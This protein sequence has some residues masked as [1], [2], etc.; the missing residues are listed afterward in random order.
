[1]KLTVKGRLIVVVGIFSVALAAIGAAGLTG[2]TTTVKGLDALYRE[3]LEP[4]RTLARITALIADNRTQIM[5]AIQHNP[6]NP[7]SKLHDHP[8][9]NHFDTLEKNRT[10]LT[11]LYKRYEEQKLAPEEAAL[12]KRFL[13]LRTEYRNEGTNPA[14]EALKAG[15][16]QQA[17]VILL[18]KINPLFKKTNDVADELMAKSMAV[19]RAEYQAADAAYEQARNLMI[20]GT[21]LAIVLGALVCAQVARTLVRQLGGEPD[22]AAAIASQIAVGDLSAQVTVKPGDTASLMAAMQRMSATIQALVA[23]TNRMSAEHDKGEIDVRIDEARFQGAFQAMAKGVNGMVGN[24]LDIIVKGIACFSEF[25]QGNLAADIEK[26]PGKKAVLNQAID[27]IRA[28]IQALVNDANTLA[29]AAVEGR[30]AVRADPARHQGEFRNIIAGLNAV[31]EAIVGP[32]N[33]INRVMAAVESG[34]LTQSISAEYRG[35][36]KALCN[37]VN[38]TV[39]K[40]AQTIGEVNA[41]AEA[42]GAA[43]GQVSATAQS[44]S[45]SSSEQAASVEQTTASVEQ[46]AGS[47]RQNAENARVADAMSAEGSRKAAEGGQAVTETVDAMRQIAQKIGIVDDIAYQTNLLALN[48]AIEAARA[49]E[50]GKGFA[51]VAA[52]V[53]KLAERSQVA[54]QEIGQLAV[55]SVGTAERAGKLLDEIVPATQKTADLVQEIT[56]TSEEQT[57]AVAQVNTAMGQ[58]NK[59]TQQNA[60]ASEELAATA[61]EMSSQ[62]ESLQHA[63]AFFKLSEH[64]RHLHSQER[65]A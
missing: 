13:E 1:M 21:L 43:T 5:L 62:A 32:V 63:M 36:M 39:D 2:M 52:E 7:L 15:Q 6:D 24:H 61:E 51:V 38:N 26:Q 41:T 10:E 58:M 3:R 23:E 9:S 22:D 29:Q 16:F 54:A 33:E 55:S 31:M 42:L 27:Q 19:A 37:T 50:H 20:G 65:F 14:L 35:Q 12:F 47:I 60:A 28:N 30:L 56:A 57:T 48:A 44:L 49:G 18:T 64:S 4:L 59:V 17:N 11:Q 34:D 8:L 53:R 46:M 40:L 45:Q 25:G